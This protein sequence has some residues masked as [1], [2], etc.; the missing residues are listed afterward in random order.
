[1]IF[2]RLAI[3]AFSIL[4][5]SCNDKKEEQKTIY[6]SSKPML[7]DFL[8]VGMIKDKAGIY[9]YNLE[10]KT[11]E[12]FWSDKREE[13]VELS[14][15]EKMQNSFFLT[16]KNFGKTGSFPFVNNIKLYMVNSET[17]K[18]DFIEEFGSGIQVFSQWVDENNFRI[19]INS[20]DKKILNYVN[21]RKILYN[22]YGKKL[23]DITEI[24][25]ITKQGYPRLSEKKIDYFSPQRKYLIE[26]RG[27]DSIGIYLKEDEEEEL[28]I[29]SNQQIKQ[30]QWD[31]DLLFLSTINV[32]P[33]NES[34]K[35]QNPETSKLIIYSLEKD[36]ILRLWEGEGIKFF[37]VTGDFL[38]FDN[39]FGKDS[40]IV[41]FSLRPSKIV[42]EIKIKNGCGLKNIPQIPAYNS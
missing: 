18:A 16:A 8:F 13:V 37:F 34:L 1:M 11:Y 4:L 7:K 20:F 23:E 30:L 35:S 29:K 24:Y 22:T 12:P 28:I 31:D 41:I 39:G 25:D 38:I 21:H 17:G 19:T 9:K 15:S 26:S 6:D 5:L 3:I 40:Q 14:Y 10:Q 33:E 27:D 36:E 32:N 42:D 2:C